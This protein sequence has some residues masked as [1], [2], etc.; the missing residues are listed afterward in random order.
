[1]IRIVFRKC[2]GR[3]ASV[4]MR[5]MTSRPIRMNEPTRA[6]YS[7][8]TGISLAK[9]LT[10]SNSQKQ[11]P[12]EGNTR[13]GIARRMN[14]PYEQV[15]QYTGFECQAPNQ[16]PHPCHCITHL[17]AELR[18]FVMWARTLS[19]R[20]P[21]TV[22]LLSITCLPTVKFFHTVL[23]KTVSKPRWRHKDPR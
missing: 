8:L 7:R 20:S 14:D 5:T 13:H 17:R 4:I 21:S 11:P 3:R 10:N 1:M 18:V 9:W 6:K 23:Y 15:R 12:D 2:H 16:P 19:S 22:L